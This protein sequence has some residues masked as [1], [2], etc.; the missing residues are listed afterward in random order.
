MNVYWRSMVE[1][2]G[3]AVPRLGPC[4]STI[5]RTLTTKTHPRVR[6]GYSARYATKPLPRYNEP[7]KNKTQ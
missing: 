4:I 5:Y 1:F 3:V 6:Y 2:V 7:T